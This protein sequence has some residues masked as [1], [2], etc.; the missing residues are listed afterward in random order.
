M[1][2]RYQ[3]KSFFETYYSDQYIIIESKSNY[4]K[5]RIIFLKI[6]RMQL[7]T[8]MLSCYFLH[9]YLKSLNK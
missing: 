2:E 3:K 8:I 1:Q 5:K 7:K 6:F 4:I 9:Y